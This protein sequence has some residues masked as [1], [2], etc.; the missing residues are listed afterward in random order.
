MITK[1]QIKDQVPHSAPVG[2]KKPRVFFLG[3]HKILVRT[4]LPRLRAL[5]YEVF[6]PPY[7]SNVL[8]QSVQ[9]AWDADQETTLPRDVFEK[10]SRY[11]FF[12]NSIS[13]EI[14]EILNAYFDAVVVTIAAGWAT[15]VAR[16]FPGTIIFRS[17]GQTARLS[18]NFNQVGGRGLVEAHGN[19]HFC[20]FAAEV[21]EDEDAWLRDRA[22]IIPYC[23]SSDVF[24]RRGLWE[25]S[26][27]DR[28]GDIIVTTPNIAG[29]IFHTAHY[30]FVNEYFSEPHF[31]LCGVQFVPVDDPRVMGSLGRDEQLQLF[32]R[33]SAY[34]YTYSDPR[35]CYLPPVEMAVLGGPVVYLKGS[36]LARYLKG[37][38]G[39]ADTIHAAQ[40]LCERLR[41]GEPA[42]RAEMQ[43]AQASLIKRYDPAEVWP[44]FDREMR[45]LLPAVSVRSEHVVEIAGQHRDDHIKTF[46]REFVRAIEQGAPVQ[47]STVER[48][49][50]RK[51]L[52]QDAPLISRDMAGL[53]N[54]LT[55]GSIAV[56]AWEVDAQSHARAIA[57]EVGEAGWVVH[58]PYINLAPGRYRV[59]F[60]VRVDKSRSRGVSDSDRVGTVDVVGAGV[61]LG[62]LPI[63]AASADQGALVVEFETLNPVSACEFRVKSNGRSRLVVSS[64]VI[65]GGAF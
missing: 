21:V 55:E 16:V 33:S 9:Y 53:K 44:I 39:E 8:D 63:S 10:L 49:A 42:L 58:G 56:A 22:V 41:A 64:I 25:R 28:T 40:I 12:Y 57:A 38:P 14:A 61:S 1:E 3:A 18:D 19:F 60:E 17:Y 59:V 23:L 2:G 62:A 35:V 6:N 29:N 30:Q 36:L 5:G 11:S 13:E 7:L 45:R 15:E 47:S 51:R 27:A 48:S 32:A 31:R 37:G 54:F 24:E 43:A 52:E 26:E 4:E 46:V 50:I 34:L 65:E 20:P